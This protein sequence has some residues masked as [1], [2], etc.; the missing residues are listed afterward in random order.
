MASIELRLSKRIKDNTDKINSLPANIQAQI[1]GKL[2][3]QTIGIAD[4]NLVEIDSASVANGEYP[5]FTANGI[6]GRSISEVQSDLS[7]LTPEYVD[8][9]RASGGCVK[10][11]A[12]R[13]G[14]KSY[15]GTS[16]TGALTVKLPTGAINCAASVQ[17]MIDVYKY[18]SSAR[19][20]YMVG[21]YLYSN[22]LHWYEAY[23]YEKNASSAYNVRF[24]S[25]TDNTEI[26][27][28]IG[29]TNSGW[30]RPMVVVRDFVSGYPTAKTVDF[31]DDGWGITIV[32][33]FE[34]VH[35]T[36]AT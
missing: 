33:A 6:K 28:S 22:S 32:S 29:E 13:N 5:Q 19:M 23:A 1:D 24:W 16:Y 4:N 18:G 9:A 7:I 35:A 14:M 11:P 2:N 20:S 3:D 36:R 10:V 12:P 30:N 8:Y 21:G 17:F 27:V 31:W 25:K 34:I 15:S 26:Y